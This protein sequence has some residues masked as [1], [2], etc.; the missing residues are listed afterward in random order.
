[1]C[2]W[3][4]GRRLIYPRLAALRA[5][6]GVDLFP[7][8]RSVVCFL[9]EPGLGKEKL[10]PSS[11]Q[12]LTSFAMGYIQ[13]EEGHTNTLVQ[14]ASHAPLLE[15]LS[16]RGLF[17][18][19]VTGPVQPLRLAYLREVDLTRASISHRNFQYLCGV[20][21][22]APIMELSIHLKQPLVE[23]PSLPPIFPVLRRLTF[24]G[25]PLI[26]HDFLERLPN[27]T[28]V[29]FIIEH[30]DSMIQLGA[31]ESLLGFLNEQFSDSLHSVHLNFGRQPVEVPHHYFIAHTLMALIPLV[32]GGLEELRYSMP[33]MVESL[34]E[35]L[36][37]VLDPSMWPTL[38][39]FSFSTRSPRCSDREL[40]ERMKIWGPMLTS[41][42]LVQ[43]GGAFGGNDL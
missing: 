41:F 26:A 43:T 17:R 27:S 24:C 4:D 13:D 16:L 30:E 33:V 40:E 8:L 21:C 19:L 18:S 23:W 37:R 42:R 32:E 9:S 31:Y 7:N 38:R 6:G 29:E 34:P 15:Q 35:E 1:M 39:V 14:L 12:S 25:D 11:L 3:M 10:L 28:L 36:Q 5:R 22:E 20:L 2:A